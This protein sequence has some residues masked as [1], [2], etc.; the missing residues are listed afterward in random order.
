MEK[1]SEL[2]KVSIE[3]GHYLDLVLKDKK[4][5]LSEGLGLIP[6]FLKFY[7]VLSEGK[8]LKE[9]WES[10]KFEQKQMI[11]KGI[12]QALNL[13]H[14][15]TEKIIEKSLHVLLAVSELYQVTK[16]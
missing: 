13:E 6:I 2:V 11:V 8:K 10:L 1:I 3:L 9:E 15:K 16:A 5:E 12:E 14:E 4:L 7:P